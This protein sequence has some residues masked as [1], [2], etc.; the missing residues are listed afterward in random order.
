M[1]VVPLFTSTSE[2][3]YP[4]PNRNTSMPAFLC[5]FPTD[6][7]PKNLLCRPNLLRHIF[8][9]AMIM[10]TVI[11]KTEANTCAIPQRQSL[12]GGDTR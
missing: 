2:Q 5:S 6:T 3:V 9:W 1:Q 11:R 4:A 10:A 8:F 12:I 7:I